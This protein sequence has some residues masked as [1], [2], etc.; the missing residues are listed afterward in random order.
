MERLGLMGRG[1][2]FPR[3]EERLLLI[4][5]IDGFRLLVADLATVAHSGGNAEFGQDIGLQ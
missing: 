5:D 4:Q 2:Y 1:F 3:P